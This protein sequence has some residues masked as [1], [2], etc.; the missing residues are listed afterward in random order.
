MAIRYGALVF[1]YHI[2][3]I[4]TP[5]H[6]RPMT[7]LPEGWTWYSVGPKYEKAQVYDAHEEIGLRRNQ[8]SWN[9][10]LDEDLKPEDIEVE[11]LPEDGYVWENPPIRLNTHCYK[12]P[13]MF[14]PYQLRYLEPNEPYQFVTDKLPLTLVPHGC[15]NLRITYFAKADL[16]NR[17]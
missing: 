17:K 15:T 11:L 14:A 1:A 8:F 4:W 16:K 13:Y 2:P 3:E 6:G 12:A 10:A 7:E 9:I 5:I